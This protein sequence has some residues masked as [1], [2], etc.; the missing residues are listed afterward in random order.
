[1]FHRFLLRVLVAG[2][3][4]VLLLVPAATAFGSDPTAGD[5]GV[6]NVAQPAVSSNPTPQ[7]TSLT[8][9]VSPVIVTTSIGA[10]TQS[11]SATTV[12]RCRPGMVKVTNLVHGRKVIACVS[13]R[14]RNAAL[15]RRHA[16]VQR[17]EPAFRG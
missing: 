5:V 14:K 9:S 11:I 15:R 10:I 12:V 6:D 1:M 8:N 2:G 16:R 17:G 7:T 13:S 4:A 3:A